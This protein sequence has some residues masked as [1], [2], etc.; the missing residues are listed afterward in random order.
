[1]R[2]KSI[3]LKYSPFLGELTSVKEIVNVVFSSVFSK[4]FSKKRNKVPKKI[5]KEKADLL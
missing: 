3:F 5:R 4:N 1:M 2:K